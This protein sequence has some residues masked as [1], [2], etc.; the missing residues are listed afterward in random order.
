[1]TIAQ[2]MNI[3]RGIMRNIANNKEVEYQHARDQVKDKEVEY[4]HARDQVKDK[5]NQE[6][7]RKKV[8]IQKIAIYENAIAKA[9]TDEER[10]SITNGP[11]NDTIEQFTGKR[12]A[13]I[14]PAS[15]QLSAHRR[16]MRE[17]KMSTGDPDVKRAA[18]E[19]LDA[20][21]E[22]NFP[23]EAAKDAEVASG[24][25]G[26]TGKRLSWELKNN[27]NL[28]TGEP[29]SSEERKDRFR[30]SMQMGAKGQKH[31]KDFLSAFTEGLG[32]GGSGNPDLLARRP[33][34]V[35]YAG[36]KTSKDPLEQEKGRA[37][38]DYK[39]ADQFSA[40]FDKKAGAVAGAKKDEFEEQ[41]VSANQSNRVINRGLKL[42]DS[43]SGIF[44]GPLANIKTGFNKYLK[45]VG[46]NL[47]GEKVQ[48]TE[49]FAAIMARNVINILGSGDLG[50]GT[51]ISDNDRIFAAKIVGGEVTLD[52]RSLRS[53]LDIN[54]RVNDANITIANRRL[55]GLRLQRESGDPFAGTSQETTTGG[56]TDD[57]SVTADEL[58]FSFEELEKAG[59]R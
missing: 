6:K 59:S 44:S 12:P 9:K 17:N 4:Q 3:G 51:G 50:A 29:L 52:E 55:E 28:D 41:I 13:D 47:V 36:Y 1:M 16:K 18:G 22:T 7:E 26:A 35:T 14:V 19:G 48:S 40:A 15:K 42:L 31:R 38:M 43:K 24:N 37:M 45:E 2:G 46:I 34:S 21:Y 58:I 10:A 23:E 11:L 5:E 8:L 33:A 27:T 20:Y 32:E 54:K 49:A 39:R 30:R 53:L 25:A 56:R 57:N